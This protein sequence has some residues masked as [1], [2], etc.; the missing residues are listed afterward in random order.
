M[1][2]RNVEMG[3]IIVSSAAPVKPHCGSPAY[4]WSS[5]YLVCGTSLT[6]F[7]EGGKG[8]G[9]FEPQAML[10]ISLPRCSAQMKWEVKGGKGAVNKKTN[11]T[12]SRSARLLRGYWDYSVIWLL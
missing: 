6:L 9:F 4:A 3:C 5:H 7:V 1:N 2:V 11:Q 12:E 10:V 8:I